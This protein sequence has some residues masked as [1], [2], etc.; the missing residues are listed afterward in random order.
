[1]RYYVGSSNRV[2]R[3][4]KVGK[5]VLCI[6]AYALAFCLAFFVSYKLVA[7]TQSKSQKEVAA[8]REE[9]SA[10]N[11]QL[12]DKEEKITSLNMQITGLEKSLEQ[13]QK[14]YDEL[15]AGGVSETTPAN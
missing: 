9:V 1:M 8:L 12:A 3:K 5:I 11:A 7:G 13:A 2:S 4:K 14:N 6:L 10:L 15:A